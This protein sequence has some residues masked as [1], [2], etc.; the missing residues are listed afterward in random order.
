[1]SQVFQCVPNFSEGKDRAVVEAIAEAVRGT[2]GALLIDYSADADHNR[3]V[4]TILGPWKGVLDAV[5]HASRVAVERIDLRRH[6]GVHPRIGAVDVVPIVPIHEA[7]KTQAE[8]VAEKIGLAL[9]DELRLPVYFY[10]WNARPGKASALPKLR[11]GGF[12]GI[13]DHELTGDRAP[14]LG[15]ARSHPTAGVSVVGARGPLIAYNVNLGT[16]DLAVAQA[17][18]L[19]IRAEREQLPELE[20]VRALG[21]FLESRGRAQVSLNLTR[22]ERTPLPAVFAFI[23]D[24][25]KRLGVTELESEII[26]AVPGSAL[27][28]MS[29]EV[30]HWRGYNPNQILETWLSRFVDE[31]HDVFGEQI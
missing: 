13:V 1:M 4:M 31:P 23:A 27:G 15:P 14:D 26:G 24:E 30:I 16:P 11:K 22:P 3:C 2:S 21:L 20:G 17:I 9:A 5:V 18:A 7:S 19:R 28:G 8:I 12:E 29:P 6:S 25:A 10:E